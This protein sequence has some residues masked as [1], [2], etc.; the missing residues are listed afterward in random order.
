[1]TLRSRRHPESTEGT[2]EGTWGEDGPVDGWAPDFL[3]DGYSYRTIVLPDDDEGPVRATLVRYQPAAGPDAVPGSRKVLYLHGWS[4][5]FFQSELA[6]YWHGQGA[7]FFALDLRKY[8]RSLRSW[9][10]PGFISSLEDYD[11]EIDE[12]VRL[13]DEEGTGGPLTIMAHSTGALVAA[14]WAERRAGAVDSLIL[15][16]PWLELQGSSVVRSAA[17]GILEP[18]VRFRP[19]AQ[20]KL[21]EIDNYW[22]SISAEGNGEWTLN[23]LWRPRYSF[24]V[25]AGWLPR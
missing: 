2:T 3:G 9:Q 24:A 14:L 1:M 5:Y 15:N 25:T 18:V 23:P 19:K 4:D 11:A 13:L 22:R 10:T 7:R 12:A 20:L 6:E 17:A 8:G 16:S 21:P